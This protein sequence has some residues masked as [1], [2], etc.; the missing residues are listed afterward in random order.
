M[1]SSKLNDG[2]TVKMP[3]RIIAALLVLVNIAGFITAAVDK[4]K[5]RRRLWRIPER[6][7]FIIA[8]LGGCPGV[9]LGLVLFRHKTRHLSFMLGIPAIFFIQLMLI[10]QFIV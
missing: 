1:H 9:Y 10:F 7:F 6:T 4:Y 5:A 2:G 8:A 3:L